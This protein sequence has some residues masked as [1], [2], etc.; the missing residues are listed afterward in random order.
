[1]KSNLTKKCNLCGNDFNVRS[2]SEFEKRVYCSKKC[3]MES[4]K[5]EKIL[6]NCKICNQEILVPPCLAQSTSYC[7]RKCKGLASRITQ[8][9]NLRRC[10]ICKNFKTINCDFSS[11]GKNSP[12]YVCK[13]CAIIRSA[14]RSRTLRGRYTTSISLAKK[15]NLIW[16]ISEENYNELISKNCFYCDRKLNETGIGLDRK[17]NSLGY[18]IEN[19]VP[20]CK[21][22]NETK[23]DNF[24]FEEMLLLAKVIKIILNEREKKNIQIKE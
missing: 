1:M 20:C 12:G 21:M 2:P 14:K 11:S 6:I 15:R 8:D 24:D 13:S 7:S 19:V 4:F 22:C 9:P 17:N 5:K 10:I 3:Q 23:L 16:D 18:T